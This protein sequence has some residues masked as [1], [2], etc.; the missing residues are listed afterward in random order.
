[1][2]P[3]DALKDYYFQTGR[4]L[5]AFK[6]QILEIEPIWKKPRGHEVKLSDF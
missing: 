4:T 5:K 1:M 3:G 2:A 6:G